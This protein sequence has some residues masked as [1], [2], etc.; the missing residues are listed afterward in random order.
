MQYKLKYPVTCLGRSKNCDIR[1]PSTLTKVSREHAEIKIH[2]NNMYVLYNQSALGTFVNGK[3]EK[4]IVL[5]NGDNISLAGV[6][7]FRF[8]NGVLSSSAPGIQVKHSSPTPAPSPIPSP[9]PVR[10]S[11]QEPPPYQQ[12]DSYQTEDKTGQ[13]LGIASVILGALTFGVQMLGGLICGWV[14]WAFGIAAIITGIMA[15]PKGAKGL[16]ITGI[17]LSVIGV[18]IQVLVLVGVFASYGW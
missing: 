12:G 3:Q 11:P 5:K 7:E 13:A 16:G 8:L 6:V 15:I 18:V 17:V 9:P 4:Q 1:L 14:G 2:K 10:F